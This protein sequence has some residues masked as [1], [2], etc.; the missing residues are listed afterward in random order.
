MRQRRLDVPLARTSSRRSGKGWRRPSPGEQATVFARR[1]SSLVSARVSSGNG[2]YPGLVMCSRAGVRIAGLFSERCTREPWL[3]RLRIER[4]DVGAVAIR[5]A[6]NAATQLGRG[7]R[8]CSQCTARPVP[9][10]A[11][12]TSSRTC[13]GCGCTGSPCSSHNLYRKWHP[14]RHSSDYRSCCISST[15]DRK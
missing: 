12:P 11:G 5:G 2:R 8:H 15:A 7:W 9:A 14:R 13:S 1:I 6:Q 3:G 10:V 4:T